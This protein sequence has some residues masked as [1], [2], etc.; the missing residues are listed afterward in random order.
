MF[1]DVENTNPF[2]TKISIGEL[3][4]GL[5]GSTLRI[6]TPYGRKRV[7]YADYTASGRA[8]TQVEDWIR[9]NALP[10]YANSHTEVSACGQ[11]M[12][13]LRRLARQHIAAAVD[14]GQSCDVI[15]CGAGATSC[16]NRLPHLFGFAGGGRSGASVSGRPVVLTGPYEHHSNILP[17]REAGAET[18]EVAEAQDGG[19]DLDDLER[20]LLRYAGQRTVIGAF[21]AA[22][23]VTG[24]LTD[25]VA[26]TQRLKVYGALAVW[27]YA[28]A[29]A[30][31]R[32][33]MQPAPDAPIDA[34]LYSPHKFPGGPGASGVLIVRKTAVRAVRPMMPG[35]GS[36]TYVS[37]WA[38]D[39]YDD[40]VLREEAG[41]PNILGDLRAALALSFRDAVGTDL[42]A[43]R[44][45]RFLER[46]R[47][48][49]RE[50]ERIILL[51]HP[52]A[53]RLPI[54]SF[55]IRDGDGNIAH[56]RLVTRLLSDLFGIQ[57]REG[58]SCAG[59]YGHRLL[60]VD[61]ALSE[62]IRTKIRAGRALAKPGWTRLNF[63]HLLDDETA[64]FIIEAV[65][66]L[67]EAIRL[68][69][70]DYHADP[71][72]GNFQHINTTRHET[73]TARETVSFNLEVA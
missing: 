62:R 51:G 73:A 36:V 61:R 14:A 24:I 58:C 38:H 34:L 5:I 72:T 54:V 71:A 21:S 43:E 37:G 41:T 53:Q 25:V 65:A 11:R 17:W 55:L 3:R 46:A 63:C 8:L 10:Y 22:S 49:W 16:V 40:L 57:A 12:N 56:H 35:G 27:D 13:Q 31:T 1:T 48:V 26:V 30:Y 39:Y 66:G 52:A 42:I 67:P 4:K 7:I 6:D 68:Y 29:A 60:G 20:H 18:I 59:P 19:V 28:C 9:E 70:G 45:A 33:S 64:D 50:D 69:A 47:K 2:Y 15:F 32:M 44:G 23:N